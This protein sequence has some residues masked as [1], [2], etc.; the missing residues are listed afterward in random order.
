MP[1]WQ[2]EVHYLCSLAVFHC[3]S[4]SALKD[5]EVEQ[6]QLKGTSTGVW[7]LE[8]AALGHVSVK[9][10]ASKQPLASNTRLSIADSSRFY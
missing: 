8:L 9:Q 4:V 5:Y 7:M 2:P 3:N 6:Y 10:A 1:C